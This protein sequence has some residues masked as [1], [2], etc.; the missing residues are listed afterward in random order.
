LA[1]AELSFLNSVG[2]L[3]GEAQ[4]NAGFSRDVKGI[5]SLAGGMY[6]TLDPITNNDVP[7]FAIHGTNDEEVPYTQETISGNTTY[8]A[9]PIINKVAAVGLKAELY[10]ISGGN[11][12]A[13]RLL[14]DD[15]ILELM[16]FLRSV[17]PE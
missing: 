3:E 1:A 4:G 13:P 16:Y 15:Y 8:G 11:H 14:S 12:E 2:G 7:L 9:V 5:I 10:T 6:R 17:I